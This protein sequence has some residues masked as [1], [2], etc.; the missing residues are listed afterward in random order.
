MAVLRLH[1]VEVVDA[2]FHQLLAV[3]VELLVECKPIL[4]DSLLVAAQ[5]ILQLFR[6]ALTMLSGPAVLGE[7]VVR[8]FLGPH[9]SH[10][11]SIDPIHLRPRG[12]V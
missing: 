7:D 5:L 9:A 4:S 11:K 10:L 3:D 2:A 6:R 1:A 12:L 8:L